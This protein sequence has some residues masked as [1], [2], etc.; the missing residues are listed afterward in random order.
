MQA[1]HLLIR[2]RELCSMTGVSRSTLFRWEKAGIFP[3][4]LRIGPHTVAWR[5]SEV[6]D[7]LA[8]KVPASAEVSQ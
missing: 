8:A 6:D 2:Q 4:R 7:W 5:K 1:P 3:A